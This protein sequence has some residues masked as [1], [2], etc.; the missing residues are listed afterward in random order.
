M[1]V[2]AAALWGKHRHIPCDTAL[3]SSPR[4]QAGCA[5]IWVNAVRMDGLVC[6]SRRGHI[7]LALPARAGFWVLDVIDCHQL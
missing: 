3:Q 2:E 5:G 1:E 6:A 7:Q 4:S